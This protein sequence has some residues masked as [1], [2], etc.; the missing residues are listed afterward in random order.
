MDWCFDEFEKTLFG[1]CF[2]PLAARSLKI[3]K[4]NGLEPCPGRPVYLPSVDSIPHNSGLRNVVTRGKMSY[5]EYFQVTCHNVQ[6]KN[7]WINSVM[8][9]SLLIYPFVVMKF[10]LSRCICTLQ[11][12]HSTILWLLY[13]CLSRRKKSWATSFMFSL[14]EE[15]DSLVDFFLNITNYK[16]EIPPCHQT[17]VGM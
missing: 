13:L 3:M 4:S 1:I 11:L 9:I 10:L 12:Q 16:T 8:L 7:M 6:A 2:L 14:L 17:W 5:V 15:L